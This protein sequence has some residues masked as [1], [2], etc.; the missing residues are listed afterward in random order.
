MHHLFNLIFGH[1]TCAKCMVKWIKCD[2]RTK[3]S[4]DP[5]SLKPICW[6]REDIVI[7]Q[8]I[9]D[10]WLHSSAKMF[11]SSRQ[12]WEITAELSHIQYVQKNLI[13]ILTAAKIVFRTHT[14]LWS[15]SFERNRHHG[16]L[17]DEPNSVTLLR[18]TQTLFRAHSSLGRAWTS[19]VSSKC[20]PYYICFTSLARKVRQ[21]YLN[22]NEK[23]L[24][25]VWYNMVRAAKWT[26]CAKISLRMP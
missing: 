11:L 24:E 15:W 22:K 12:K 20:V 26:M 4:R 17:F 2:G 6:T 8:T 7:R 3:Y 19:C 9:Q 1:L 23:R 18:Q 25:G 21:F 16:E 10:H 5:L 14:A 13:C